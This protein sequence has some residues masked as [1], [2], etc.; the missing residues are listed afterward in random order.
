MNLEL[1][2][3]G[4]FDSTILP[5]RSSDGQLATGEGCCLYPARQLFWDIPT[6]LAWSQQGLPYGPLQII[7]LE[8][9][10][11]PG[12]EEPHLTS[13]EIGGHIAGLEFWFKSPNAWPHLTVSVGAEDM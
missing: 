8:N 1:P 5:S 11:K 4:P 2:G 7:N 13:G 6:I 12:P 10:H 3:A 9:Y